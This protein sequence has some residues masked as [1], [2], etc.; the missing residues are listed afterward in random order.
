M[1]IIYTLLLFAIM[2]GATT[3][4]TDA[5]AQ[6]NTER[7]KAIH[8]TVIS[9][10]GTLTSLVAPSDDDGITSSI[11]SFGDILNEILVAAQ[12]NQ[13]TV[14]ELASIMADMRTDLSE[15]HAAL[16]TQD[17]TNLA[18]D[19]DFL[20]STVTRNHATILD[21]LDTIEATLSAIEGRLVS[22]PTTGSPTVTPGVTPGAT[23]VRDDATLEVSAYTYKASGTQR[24]IGGETVYDLDLTFSCTGPANI[25]TIS[26]NVKGSTHREIIPTASPHSTTDQNYLTV[27]GRVLY[28]S[29]FESSGSYLVFIR[30]VS[31]DN[32]RSLATG[33]TLDFESRQHE[34]GGQIAASTR[35]APGFSY[36]ITVD[37]FADRNTTCAIGT[38]TGGIGG[39]GGTSALPRSDTVLLDATLGTGLIRNF[40]ETIS[41]NNN[42]VDITSI[43]TGVVG[44]QSGLARFAE[45]SL[46]FLDGSNDDTPDVEIDFNSGDGTLVAPTYPISFSNGD[47]RV[48]GKI[49]NAENLLIE[50]DYNTVRG[51]SCSVVD[52]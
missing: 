1:R 32:L 4:A 12:A 5:Y 35:S 3:I 22:T 17:G 23:L 16:S 24:T 46:T 52:N 51:G 14:S 42:P 31:F 38:G 43:E 36:E 37:Y 11:T 13:Q 48:S 40:N 21:R 2:A 7:I 19:I 47:L 50:I 30:S 18:G 39:T 49:P 34:A 44:W 8:E 20:A 9:M 6:S 45:L 10:N 29:K 28:D 25:D 27:D 15:V 26:T 41:C 33:D